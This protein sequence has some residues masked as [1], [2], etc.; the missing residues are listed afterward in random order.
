MLQSDIPFRLIR[1]NGVTLNV[2]QAG[3]DDGRLVILLH[4]FPEFWY[5]WR[6]QIPYLAAQGLRVWAPDQRGYNLS[7]KPRGVMA[8]ARDELAHDVIGLIQAA[9]V[10]RARIVGHDWG[11]LVAWWLANKFPERVEKLAILNVPHHHVAMRALRQNPAQVARSWYAFAFQMPGVPEMMLRANNFALGIS[12]LKST[13]R[14]GAFTDADLEHYREAW[15]KPGALTAMIHWYR[16]AART[17]SQVDDPRIHPSTLMIWGAKDTF[18]S[19]EMAQPSIDLCDD[20]RLVMIENATHWVQH[21]EAE[22]VNALLG[23]FLR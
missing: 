4:G 10:D 19:R 7:D 11:A 15:S 3:P 5:G 16:A 14:K 2:A 9:G 18:L 1:T 13:S 20:G 6:H 8:Y 17:A 21:E 12:A 23:E 22:R